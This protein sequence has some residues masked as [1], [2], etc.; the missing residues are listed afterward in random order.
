MRLAFFQLPV[1]LRGRG[2]VR[3]ALQHGAR[4]ALARE[5]LEQARAAVERIVEAVPALLEEGMSGHLAGEQRAGL[6]QLR[7]DERVAGLPDERSSAVALDPRR[8]QAGRLHVVDDLR[9]GV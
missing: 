7:L 9:A 6:L 5:H 4:I 2:C 8:E 3:Q 1:D